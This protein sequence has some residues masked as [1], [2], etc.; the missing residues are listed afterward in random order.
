MITKSIIL[1]NGIRLDGA[2]RLEY[3]NREK[4]IIF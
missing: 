4:L 3:Y 1:E 2:D